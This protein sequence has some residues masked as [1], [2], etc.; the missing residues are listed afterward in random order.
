MMTPKN[1]FLAMLGL[2]AIT[3]AAGGGVFYIVDGQLKNKANEVNS[4]H[5]D[6][7]ILDL[8]IRNSKELVAEFERYRDVEKVLDEVLPPE[9]VQNSII[10]EILDIAARNNTR[11]NSISFPSSNEGETDFSK[12]QT[13][14]VESVPG[15]LAVR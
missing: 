14:I 2:L 6:L 1:V 10:A 15:V 8:K 3:I 13:S 11:L 9:K 12:T 7:D 4:L 5:A